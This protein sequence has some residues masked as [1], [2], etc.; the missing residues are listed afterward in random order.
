MTYPQAEMPLIELFETP[1]FQTPAIIVGEPG[2]GRHRTVVPVK[3]LPGNWE[4]FL[5]SQ[6]EEKLRIENV[7]LGQTE[8]GNP[9]LIEVPC[10]DPLAE[11]WIGVFKTE[12][13]FRG[14]NHHKFPQ[15]SVILAEGII[16]QGAAGRM[17]SGRQYV[18]QLPFDAWIE[19]EISGRLYGRPGKFY[20]VYRRG[21]EC[22][23]VYSQEAW[24]LL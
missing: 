15:G 9:K 22:P 5:D 20:S 19:W 14:E 18:V 1:V 24:E 23:L 12:I 8:R 6:G 13:G 7:T 10:E 21:D 11:S 17:G 4:R 16:A 2:R 3:L